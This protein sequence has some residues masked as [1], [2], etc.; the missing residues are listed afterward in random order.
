MVQRAPTLGDPDKG[1]VFQYAELRRGIAVVRGFVPADLMESAPVRR[2]MRFSSE[3]AVVPLVLEEVSEFRFNGGIVRGARFA[4]RLDSTFPCGEFRVEL[5]DADRGV[6]S[7]VPVAVGM[8]FPLAPIY[9]HQGLRLPDGRIFRLSRNGGFRLF[10]ASAI[11][12]V[13]SECLF[14][15]ELLGHATL[16]EWVAAVTRI[17]YFFWRP[18]HR[19]R[20][21]IFSDKLSNPIDSAYSIAKALVGNEEFARERIVPFYLVDGRHALRVRLPRK[22]RTVRYLSLRHR[23]LFMAAEASVTSEHG[24]SPFAPAAPYSDITAWQL[25]VSS[26]HGL[27]HHDLSRLYGRDFYNFNL[28]IA[29]VEREAEYERGGLWGYAPE[30][31]VCTGLP[32]WDD[33]ESA[34]GK[35]ICLS[36]T[37]RTSL[38]ESS[39]P[40]TKEYGFG[41]RLE[42]S[43]YRRRL[44]SLFA[45]PKLKELA[46]ES[47]YAIDFLPHPLMRGAMR[48]FDIPGHVN[49]IP[50]EMPYEDIYRDASLLVTDYSSVAMDMAYLGK[51]VIYYQFD[52]DDFYATQGYT[53]SYFSWADDG[54]GPVLTDET[55]VVAEIARLLSRGC[56]REEKYEKRARLFF[57][58]RDKGNGLRACRAIFKRLEECRGCADGLCG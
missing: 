14:L 15:C 33:R 40:V 18:F 25:K 48:F 52:H 4:F 20:Y 46:D 1:V 45:N 9:R 24:Y 28:M 32:R 3:S 44:N 51:P 49:L 31:I 17:C 38:A 12:M 27:V 41:T 21:W 37:W 8:N 13:A 6:A 10:H 35:R 47:G 29:G 22:L 56:V 53:E 2:E 16:P 54:F 7:E 34:P 50:E 43:E 23:L 11:S 42:C 58:V 55:A 26:L 30:D 57:P 19:G 36:F 5:L 39:D